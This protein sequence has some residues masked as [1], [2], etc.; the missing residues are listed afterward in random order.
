MERRL[1][2][3]APPPPP[4]ARPGLPACDWDATRTAYLDRFG[5]FFHAHLVAVGEAPPLY[6]LSFWDPARPGAPVVYASFGAPEG[7]VFLEAAAPALG[8]GALVEEAARAFL[9]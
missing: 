2:T 8:V 9:D 5:P 1:R 4:K 3:P 7:E 6:V